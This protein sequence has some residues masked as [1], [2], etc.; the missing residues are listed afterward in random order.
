MDLLECSIC[1]LNFNN[2]SRRPRNLPCGHCFCSPCLDRI[3]S[4]GSKTCP[5][6]RQN[7]NA[8][9]AAS[10]GINFILEDLAQKLILSSCAPVVTT[11]VDDATA[12][13]CPKHI[14]NQ[15][16]FTCTTHNVKICHSCAVLDHPSTSCKLISFP[17][18]IKLYKENTLQELK[19]KIK[20]VEDSLNSLT[21]YKKLS[22]NEIQRCKDRIKKL[23]SDISKKEE[24]NK[25]TSGAIVALIERRTSLQSVT[26]ELNSTSC[27]QDIK[28]VSQSAREIMSK[29]D[30][31]IENVEATFGKDMKTP[32]E[33]MFN[34]L[35]KGDIINVVSSIKGETRASQLY[36]DEEYRVHMG[37]LEKMKFMNPNAAKLSIDE[38]R[39]LIFTHNLAYIT[40]S[41]H[42]EVLGTV[43]FKIRHEVPHGRQFMTLVLGSQGSSFKG[44]K[45]SGRNSNSITLTTSSKEAV[46]DGLG[47]GWGEKLEIIVSGMLI[48][49]NDNDASF[50]I[51]TKPL[52][53]TKYHTCFGEVESGMDVILEA[54]SQQ[55]N[56]NDVMICKSGV[57]LE[58]S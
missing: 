19:T 55:Y 18:E 46:T 37:S 49:M 25:E 53:T 41:V 42:E 33:T 56:I 17:E 7:H 10:L 11:E 2:S 48:P 1:S 4:K 36:M 15:L 57:I 24:K 29:E 47:I 22:E 43:Y 16:Y 45:F 31:Q 58:V 38:V 14:H 51:V 34:I 5:T 54:S 35:Y 39:P 6:C 28:R 26:D 27:V 9:D 23:L 3:I 13:V 8:K 50:S 20:R 21:V 32:M 12:G 30:S 52:L 44:A 40:L